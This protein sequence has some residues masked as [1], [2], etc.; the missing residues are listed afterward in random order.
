MRVLGS[1]EWQPSCVYEDA[2]YPNL[3]DTAR[4]RWDK[5]R[6]E[7]RAER[8]RSKER[9]KVVEHLH[10]HI[11]PWARNGLA[12]VTR[13]ARYQDCPNLVDGHLLGRKMAEQQWAH[14]GQALAAG[15][16]QAGDILLSKQNNCVML[17]ERGMLRTYTN[18]A[19]LLDQQ[20]ISR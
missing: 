15:L 8:N 16:T 9:T 6:E 13:I 19:P 1:I 18:L 3:K 17:G 2:I 5:V 4:P 20:Q 7:T 10:I 11:I 14:A 12:A